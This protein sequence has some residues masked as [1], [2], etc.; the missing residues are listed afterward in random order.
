LDLYGG[1]QQL[2]VT[3]ARPAPQV[4]VAVFARATRRSEEELRADLDTRIKALDP[5]IAALVAAV[6]SEDILDRF[7]RW[8]AAQQRHG[9]VRHGL[10]AHSL[11][12]ACIA[13]RLSEAYG[14]NGLAHD[15][16][17]VIAALLLHDVGKVHTLPAVAGA[18]LPTGAAEC[19]HVTRSVLMVQ[20]AATRA[21]CRLPFERLARLTH[22]ILGH[23]GRREWGAAVEP[24]TS[25]AW[26]V[27]L[28]DLAE[29]RLW[30]WSNEEAQP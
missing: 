8:P 18:P 20:A 2:A 23:H 12:V 16:D 1:D 17:V 5:E 3:L 6:L 26:L 10:L 9:A 13:E 30:D 15:R 4:D 7:C 21:Q 11:R 27:H 24:Q 22:A 29:S 19:D 28:A 14:P 25:D